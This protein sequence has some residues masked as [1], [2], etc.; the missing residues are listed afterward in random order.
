MPRPVNV[1]LAEVL[2]FNSVVFV[3]EPWGS[4]VTSSDPRATPASGFHFLREVLILQTSVAWPCDPLDPSG[5]GLSEDRTEADQA[6]DKTQVTTSVI[7]H[8]QSVSHSFA[9]T[10]NF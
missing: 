3:P 2:A 7:L 8:D 5:S 1:E 6:E 9:Q 10:W 4:V